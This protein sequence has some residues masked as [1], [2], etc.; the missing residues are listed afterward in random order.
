MT[1][2]ELGNLIDGLPPESLTRTAQRNEYDDDELAEFAAER[3]EHGPFSHLELLVCHLID[4]V[5]GLG[6]GLGGGKGS[7]P[8]YPRPGVAPTGPGGRKGRMSRSQMDLYL[9]KRQIKN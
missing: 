5:V 2:R 1:Y 8:Q 9:T 3:T 7:P 4:V 6:H